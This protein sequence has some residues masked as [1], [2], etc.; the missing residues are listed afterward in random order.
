MP[1][2]PPVTSAFCPT[3]G[4]HGTSLDF[5]GFI[6]TLLSWPQAT[7]A[8][9]D[10]AADKRP[11]TALAPPSTANVV[12]VAIALPEHGRRRAAN[13]GLRLSAGDRPGDDQHPRDPVRSD[14]RNPS[15]RAP[16]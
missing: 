1:E 6:L 5:T 13:G 3:S 12:S 4:R 14:R 11:A 10:Y 9:N 2:L 15:H 7:A 16:R 8:R